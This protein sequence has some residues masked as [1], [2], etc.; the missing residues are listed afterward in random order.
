MVELKFAPLMNESTFLGRKSSWTG[1][2]VFR[3]VAF[4]SDLV[5]P[6]KA[7]AAAN[8]TISPES[9]ILSTSSCSF[10][11]ELDNNEL[12]SDKLDGEEYL[13][14]LDRDFLA[15]FDLLRAN[16]EED[17]AF[18]CLRFYPAW[19]A[20]EVVRDIFPRWLY[21]RSF[22]SPTITRSWI[23]RGQR[24]PIVNCLT[25]RNHFITL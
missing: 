14:N 6:L 19:T 2:S 9:V 18:S 23:F 1:R 15:P 10:T 3:T 25:S 21:Y 7:A 8:S 11:E 16:F 24:F 17:F 12:E 20:E 5:R 22:I 4:L 13:R